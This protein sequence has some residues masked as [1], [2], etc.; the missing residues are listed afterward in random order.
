MIAC[1]N[2]ECEGQVTPQFALVFG[3]HQ[4]RIHACPDCTT[5]TDIKEGAASG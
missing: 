1:Q 4:D 3:D 2:P 5:M